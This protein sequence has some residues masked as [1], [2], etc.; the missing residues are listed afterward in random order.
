[1]VVGDSVNEQLP[2]GWA[3]TKLDELVSLLRGVTYNNS[4]SS[5][6]AHEGYL[7]IIRANN[8]QKDKLILR[9]FVY[10]QTELV[11]EIQKIRKNDIIVA[12][13]SGSKSVVGKT[14][15]S[16]SDID[17]GFGAFCG[18]LRPTKLVVPEIISFYTRGSYYRN[19]VSELS[20]GANINNLKPAHFSELDFPLPPFAEQKVIAEKLDTLLAQVDNTKARL[21][22]IPEILKRFRQSVL[23]AAVSGKLTEE[24]RATESTLA[25]VAEFQNGFAFKSEW[26]EA[27][28]QYQVIK[29]GNIRDGYLALENSPAFVSHSIAEEFAKF[30]PKL[31]DTLLSMTGTRFKKDYG[32]GCLVN[33]QK[34]LLINQRVGRL[35]PDQKCV[36]PAYLNIFV[37]SDKFRDQFFAGETGGVNQGNVGSKHIMSIELSLPS[38]NIQIE[39]VRR[40]EEMFAFADRIEQ[41][42]QAAL[43]R[44]N[45]LTQSILAKAFRGELT[46]D[47]RAANPELISGEHSAE[48]LLTRIKAER[49]KLK[50]TKKVKAG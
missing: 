41:A 15:K 44:V 39:I 5:D 2:P 23:A 17:A 1:M 35:I 10:V 13:S 30:T 24:W 49:V 36:L 9:D 22:R 31:G 7:P 3:L 11:K 16:V 38:I 43:S 42:A 6:T 33:D 20:A 21:E 14:A 40:V 32:F 19:K 47:W 27:T 37:R 4:Q 45:N 46:A 26:F 29:L 48:A 50:P 18:L 8:I 34:N 28:G 25:E 12:M